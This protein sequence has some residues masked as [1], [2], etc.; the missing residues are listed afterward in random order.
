MAGRASLGLTARPTSE[1][2][3]KTEAG[4]GNVDPRYS[5]S[6]AAFDGYD[7]PVIFPEIWLKSGFQ[8]G[9]S[10]PKVDRAIKIEEIYGCGNHAGRKG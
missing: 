9:R 5:I 10:Q 6:A 4:D 3:E 8:G 2:G 1:P 7:R